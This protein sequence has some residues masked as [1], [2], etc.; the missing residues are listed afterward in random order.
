MPKMRIQIASIKKEQYDEEKVRG[1]CH[2]SSF[3]FNEPKGNLF[4]FISMVNN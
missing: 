4:F 3:F 2:C 1:F